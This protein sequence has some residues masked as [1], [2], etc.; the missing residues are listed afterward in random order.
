MAPAIST[1]GPPSVVAHRHLEISVAVTDDDLGALRARVLERV[2]KALLDK[3]VRGE[4]DPGRERL[5]FAFD[6]QLDG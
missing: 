1:P 4:I 5:R 3:P 6:P 2:R